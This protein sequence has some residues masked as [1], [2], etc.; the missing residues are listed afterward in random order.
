[1]RVNLSSMPSPKSLSAVSLSNIYGGLNLNDEPVNVAKSQSPNMLNLWYEDGI[2]KKRPGF[3]KVFDASCASRGDGM[4][5]FYDKLFN[6]FVVYVDGTAIRY[7]DPAA[8]PYELHTVSG[9]KIPAGAPHG[10]FFAF[11]ERLYYKARDVYLRLSY[12]SGALTAE[13]ILVKGS[14]GYEVGDCVYTPIVAINRNPDGSGGD[15]YQ[16]ENRINP[17]KAVWFD[18][19]KSTYDYVLPAHGCRV[20]KVQVGEDSVATTAETRSYTVG[21]RD[22]TI[23]DEDISDDS[24]DYTKIRFSVPLYVDESQWTSQ[25][26]IGSTSGGRNYISNIVY[27][28]FNILAGED[29]EYIGG[30]LIRPAD[31][32]ECPTEYTESFLDTAISMC[33]YSDK[34]RVFV[35]DNG[36]WCN[37]FILAPTFEI[38]EYNPENTEMWMRGYY[39]VAYRYSTNQ[40]TTY[41]YSGRVNNGWHF[42]NNVVYSTTDVYLGDVKIIAK[43]GPRGDH[44]TFADSFSSLALKHSGLTSQDTYQL[45]WISANKDLVVFHYLVGSNKFYVTRWD[46]A[47]GWFQGKGIRK[48]T[49]HRNDPSKVDVEDMTNPGKLGFYVK[50]IVWSGVDIVWNRYVPGDILS[51]AFGTLP[52]DYKK[53]AEIAIYRVKRDHP[54]ANV[55]GKFAIARKGRWFSVYVDCG[56]GIKSYNLDTGEFKAS[57]F[58]SEVYVQ[59]PVSDEINLDLTTPATMSNKLRVTYYKENTDAMKAIADCRYATTF[60]GTDAACAVMGGCDSQPNAIF[61]S[62]N[63]SSGVDATYYPMDQFNLC[64]TYQDPVTGFGKQQS[65]LVV[66][67]QNHT[68]R[69]SYEIS[70]I[71]G[72]K[73]IDLT[74]ATINAEHGCDL[75]WSIALCG[76]NLVWMHSKHGVMYLKDTSAAYENM[77]V[78]ISDNVN[79]APGRP[80]LLAAIKSSGGDDYCIAI[81]DG[82][83]YYASTGNELY[84]WD[85][86]LSSVGDGISGLSWTRHKTNAQFKPQAAVDAS[87]HGI[88]MLS[89]TGAVFLSDKTIDTDAGEKINFFYTTPLLSLGGY[90]RQKNVVKVILTI[91]SDSAAAFGVKY[92]GEGQ[93]RTQGI[94]VAG[95]E[96]PTPVILKPRGIHVNHFQLSIAGEGDGGDVG[97]LSVN[98]MYGTQGCNR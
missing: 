29:T 77:I 10:T 98:I 82:K 22:F 34:S 56:M 80:G 2:L 78:V 30:T 35:L 83:R 6:G 23:L 65:S 25:P 89:G 40:W 63:G 5:W 12:Q 75:P 69:A 76:N 96:Y 20:A 33:P 50:N 1:M 51:H 7:F 8:E 64:G 49:I 26:W 93:G 11:D 66:F 19:D 72:R 86:S 97:I 27:S 36:T 60:G 88:F 90:Y 85:F 59:N 68:S 52:D 55:T 3:K 41:D 14:S 15:S 37:V 31:T 18:V 28:N 32:Q 67:Q 87:P 21:G 92:G 38:E 71:S 91:K 57:G 43:G 74:M 61:W 13:N 48:V 62:G 73:Y 79:G 39:R 45:L 16:P 9:T 95:N 44:Q 4:V 17:M 70:E 58:V 53:L 94:C 42:A 84:V 47:N 46:S 81:E 24:T 54:E